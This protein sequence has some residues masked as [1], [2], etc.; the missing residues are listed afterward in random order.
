MARKKRPTRRIEPSDNDLV[1]PTL[2]GLTRLLDDLYLIREQHPE[3]YF[4]IYELI[5]WLLLP[6]NFIWSQQHNKQ[7]IRHWIARWR[8]EN[9]D[10]WSGDEAFDNASE[11][12][13]GHPAA[14]AAPTIRKAYQDI[15]QTLSSEQRR[16]RTYRRKPIKP[17][18]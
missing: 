16:P 17:L 18:R 7:A 15:E 11:Q 2:A 9:G 12:L 5:G 13:K 4:R 10:K 8:I 14:A 3:L 6:G 1:P